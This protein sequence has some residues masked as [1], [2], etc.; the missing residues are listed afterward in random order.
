MIQKIDKTYQDGKKSLETLLR[1]KAY[2]DVAEHLKEQGINIED[3]S[4]EDVE[5]LVAAKTNDM[6]NGLKGF[7]A[8]AAITLVLSAL[9][10]V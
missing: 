1:E 3:V 7:G 6:K 10:G 2:D 4:D 8:G 5:T 9:L